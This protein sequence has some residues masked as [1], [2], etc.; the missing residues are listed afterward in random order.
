VF[1]GSV[2]EA[3]E[4]ISWDNN[5]EPE[6]GSEQGLKAACGRLAAAAMLLRVAPDKGRH[7]LLLL[8]S[9]CM[10]RELG[11]KDALAFLT[12]L[13]VAMVPDRK[14]KVQAELG[15]MVADAVERLEAEEPVAGWPKLLEAIGSKRARQ[16]GE[17]LGIKNPNPVLSDDAIALQLGE[18][19]EPMARHVALW[20]RWLFWTGSKWEADEKLLH[21][22]LAREFMRSLAAK[23]KAAAE[24]LGDARTIMRVISLARSNKE[25][26]A[27]AG[28]WHASSVMTLS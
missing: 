6:E 24:D 26:V 12:P 14:G 13:A 8:L 20:G 10:V 7:D 11:E 1:P 15:R 27:R 18:A 23:N 4:P 3:G 22:T 5:G 28:D 2:H 19:W 9:G 25:L 16:L 21:V 17:W